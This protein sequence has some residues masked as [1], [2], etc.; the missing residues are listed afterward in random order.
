MSRRRTVAIVGAGP[1]GL[2]AALRLAEAGVKVT[3][4]DAMASPARKLL[5]AGRGGLNLTHSEPREA[6]L[7]RYGPARA[8]LEPM[9]DAFP[10]SALRAFVESLGEATFVGSSGRVFPKSFKASPLVRAWLRR[11]EAAGVA[12]RPRHRFAGFAAG[13]GV[14]VDGPQ[15]R[16]TV[17]ADATL[18][19]LGGASWP[20][21]GS[22]GGWVPV[23][24]AA[25]IAV[26]PLA[27]SNMGVEIGWSA[28]FAGRFAG[29]PLKN[30]AAVCGTMR[31]PGEAMITAHGLEGGAIYALSP[32]IRQALAS[33]GR[34]QLH[35]DLKPGLEPSAIAARLGR[36]RRGDSLSST[37]RK[38]LGLAPQA[39]ALLREASGGNL[40]RDPLA[41]AALIRQV[42]L[43]LAGTRPLERAISTAGGIRL[44]AVTPGLELTALPGVFVAGEMLDWE[45]PTGGYLLQA[46][47]ATAEAA[48]RAIAA[49]LGLDLARQADGGW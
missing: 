23:L 1:A 18:L 35:V 15:G 33:G 13:G 31:A 39:V 8:W 49:R 42:P 48:A 14:L 41:L 38:R 28:D 27:P 26:V 5:L 9:L 25:G 34:A 40:P 10:P 19:A 29:E 22:D 44:E 43:T 6:F 17:G 2:F 3:L 20:R 32:A 46:T 47:F 21:M 37:L 7:T 11:L 30:V 36:A 16:E 12:L 24:E 4:F 45:A